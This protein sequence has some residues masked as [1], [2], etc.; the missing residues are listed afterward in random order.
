MACPVEH[1]DDGRLHPVGE[2]LSNAL[3]EAAWFAVD[4]GS[5]KERFVAM[6]FRAAN[7]AFDSQASNRILRKH[8]P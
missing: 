2:Q 5:N 1:D 8:A 7:E 4:N 3:W 6:V